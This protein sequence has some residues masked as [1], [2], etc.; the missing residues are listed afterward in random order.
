MKLTTLLSVAGWAVTALASSAAIDAE[1]V[2]AQLLKQYPKH[3]AWDVLG[4][5]ALQT[6]FNAGKYI[7]A[8]TKYWNGVN[9]KN[10]PTCAFFPSNAEQV[11]TAVKLLNKYSDAQFALKSGGHNFNFGISSTDGGVLF[12]F[13]QNLASVTRSED[14]EAFHVGPGARWGDVYEEASKTNQVVVGGRLGNIGVA[15]FALGGGLSYYSAQ[16]V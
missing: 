2:C 10:R 15:G 6:V 4:S 13:N 3:V 5:N 9:R 11:S 14:G 1:A 16:Y 12:S 7:E 8:N